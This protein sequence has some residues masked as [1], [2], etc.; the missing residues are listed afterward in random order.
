MLTSNNTVRS[1][2]SFARVFHYSLGTHEV[3]MTRASLR[4]VRPTWCLRTSPVLARALSLSLLLQSW[5][6]EP[7][8]HLCFSC[9]KSRLVISAQKT[10]NCYSATATK[11][12]SSLAL[13][14]SC[15]ELSSWGKDPCI[16]LVIVPDTWDNTRYL[17]E[18]QYTEA[19]R[20]TFLAF[21]W[22]WWWLPLSMSQDPESPRHVPQGSPWIHQSLPEILRGR[23]NYV[24]WDGEAHS[25]WVASC[26]GSGSW[27]LYKGE[28]WLDTSVG[29]CLLPDCGHTGPAA[30]APAVVPWPPWWSL[31]TLE[32]WGQNEPFL[33]QVDFVRTFITQLKAAN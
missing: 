19:S 27:M 21:I 6:Q 22:R 14:V 31:C 25:W 26:H 1:E 17:R 29:P 4:E 11:V 18:I 12:T 23:W 7:V 24:C 5:L 9:F 8:P 2:P 32:L 16:L 13:R 10:F 20:N 28:S 33:Y 3:Q 15:H 30:S